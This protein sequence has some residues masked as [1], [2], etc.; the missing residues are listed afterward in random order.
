[1]CVCV[2]VP[3]SLCAQHACWCHGGQME[4]GSPGTGVI[5]GC[6]LPDGVLGGK[7]RFYVRTVSALNPC[8]V[9]SAPLADLAL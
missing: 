3:M 9:S 1:M 5:G 4:K 6:E 8:A 7:F 2:R